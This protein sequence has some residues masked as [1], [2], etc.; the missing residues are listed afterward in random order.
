MHP[1]LTFK[2]DS[3]NTL[4]RKKP[5]ETWDG[6]C[7]PSRKRVEEEDVGSDPR[8]ASHLVQASNLSPGNFTG[9]LIVMSPLFT[10][11]NPLYE[12]I[13]PTQPLHEG[14]GHT[15]TSLTGC[16]FVRWKRQRVCAAG[17]R[18]EVCL[19]GGGFMR[20]CE[21]GQ[22]YMVCRT[23]CFQRRSGGWCYCV[24]FTAQVITHC[25]NTAPLLEPLQ[26]FTTHICIALWMYTA[27]RI[28]VL[29]GECWACR[30]F[31]H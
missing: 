19:R 24:E 18:L 16:V 1:Y 21:T 13:V 2:H 31:A 22:G 25:H 26:P 23:G 8:P 5:K 17:G 10:I 12:S 9:H 27:S 28:L 14:E 30:L 11:N 20:W 29:N 7:R 3:Q 6:S 15:F 4:D